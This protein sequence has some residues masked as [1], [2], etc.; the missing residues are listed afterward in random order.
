MGHNGYPDRIYW[1][2]DGKVVLM[3][4]KLPGRKA[5]PIQQVVH[6]LLRHLGHVV[7]IVTSV[8]QGVQLLRD[9][10]RHAST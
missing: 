5:S 7:H 4:F 6:D 8:Q 3:E 2:P 10:G 9:A 1:L